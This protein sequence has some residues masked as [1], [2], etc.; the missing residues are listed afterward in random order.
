MK[1]II[2]SVLVALV[3][4]SAT[5]APK[6]PKWVK[7]AKNSVV[8]IISYKEGKEYN[9]GQGFI[10]NGNTVYTDLTF[11]TGA[12]SIVTIDG[13]EIARSAELLTGANGM[14]E[15]AKFTINLVYKVGI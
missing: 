15:V 9:Q 5:S 7:G 4:L 8:K 14:Y 3:S 1:K 6:Q 11:M 10:C 13:K 2:L 12:D